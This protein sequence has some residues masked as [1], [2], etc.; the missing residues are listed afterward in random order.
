M[1]EKK[2]QAVIFDLD[3]TLLNTL[4]DLK[5]SVNYALKSYGMPERSLDEIRHFVG[6][7]VEKLVERAVADD[8]EESV[9]EK[10]FASFK[11]HYTLHCN[12]K[13]GLYP[14]I[15]KLLAELKER[16]FK[17][18]IVSNKLQEG[19]DVLQKQYFNRYL[20]VAI[21]ARE[22]IGKKPAPDTVLEALRILDLPKEEAVYIGDSEVD[23]ATAANTGMNCITVAW[24][25][26][27][28][29]EQEDAGATMFVE[30]PEEII[31]LLYC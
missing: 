13:T 15:S 7:G 21:G 31:P 25:F 16:G 29:K 30:K 8:T 14:E 6:N 19:V 11:E 12:D 20:S 17:M 26:R 10:V 1:S 22:G 18:A 28:R 23:I 5:N 27:T 9:R 24:G 3:G 2:Y 4:E